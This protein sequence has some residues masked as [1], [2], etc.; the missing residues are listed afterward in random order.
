MIQALKLIANLMQG[1][2]PLR[3][4]FYEAANKYHRVAKSGNHRFEFERLYIDGGDPWNYQSDSYELQKYTRTLN[5]AKT[6]RTNALE[7]GSSVGIFTQRLS[8]EFERVTAVDFSTEAIKTARAKT[9]DRTNITFVEAPLESLSLNERFDVIFCAEVFFYIDPE[10]N[11]QKICRML[12]EHI[13]PEGNIILVEG[14]K[15]G[16]WEAKL[17]EHFEVIK[18]Q[19]FDEPVRPYKIVTYVRRSSPEKAASSELQQLPSM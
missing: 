15:I 11:G 12:A 4:L 16:V 8:F 13:A 7:L 1:R 19:V 10:K 17:N 6:A 2:A 3:A 18:R 14:L 9:K 5:S